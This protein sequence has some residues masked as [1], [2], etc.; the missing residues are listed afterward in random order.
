MKTI[1]K[2]LLQESNGYGMYLDLFFAVPCQGI[3]SLMKGR[4]FSF[5]PFR[6]I[7]TGPC[8]FYILGL[9]QKNVA[10]PFFYNPLRD[11]VLLFSGA[12]SF[13]KAGG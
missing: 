3:A 8:G 4:R 10:G 7:S 6:Y 12:L 5:H 2:Y 9:L 11:R 1:R 13:K